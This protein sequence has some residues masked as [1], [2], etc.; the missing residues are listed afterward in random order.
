M[1]CNPTYSTHPC[2][3]EKAHRYYSRLH[4]PV[5][6]K[7]NIQ[8]NYCNRKYDCVN[9]SR[10]GV[11]SQ[12]LTVD[13]SFQRVMQI[14]S[15][16]QDL[17][18][19]G[20]AGPGD[21]L[22]NPQKTFETFRRIRH[23]FPDLSLCLST[24]GLEL[25][26]YID[27][28]IETK[29]NHVTVTINTTNPATAAQVY[30]NVMVDG[31]R[32]S[33]K[34]AMTEFLYRQR[35][36][37]KL[38]IQ[39]GILVKINSLLMPGINDH[40]LVGLS[41]KLKMMGITL[42][43]IMPLMAKPEY[44]SLFGKQERPTPTHQQVED[45]RQLCGIKNQ[46]VHCRQCRADAAGKLGDEEI[47]E[48][49]LTKMDDI[50]IEDDYGL[51]KRKEWRQHVFHLTNLQPVILSTDKSRQ[52]YADSNFKIAVCSHGS[53]F[54]DLELTLT[55]EFYIYQVIKGKA[56]LLNVRKIDT[57]EKTT[58]VSRVMKSIEGCQAIL[59]H[60]IGYG[61]FKELESRGIMPISDLSNISIEQAVTT[62][63]ERL[64]HNK[65]SNVKTVKQVVGK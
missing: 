32:R 57:T 5:A 10:P 65:R 42:H 11:T 18:V 59:S 30:A 63:T 35:Q 41:K 62:A 53:E 3:S 46:M 38:L 51:K 2:Y 52:M 1:T 22:A 4:L 17:S 15:K 29:V 34:Q 20:I 36:G 45:I 61:L 21:A 14:A 39:A 56:T 6:P 64:E 16:R 24:N 7:C 47:I 54:A 31:K 40:E 33:D 9:E 13:Q 48:H 26:N 58:F 44:G 37:V 19:V 25:V 12:L 23:S 50:S 49:N 60:K 27:E 43:N 28:I 55:R 8:C